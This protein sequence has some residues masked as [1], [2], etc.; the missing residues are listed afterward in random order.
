M[1][2]PVTLRQAQKFIEDHH[3]HNKPP[4][5]WKFGVGLVVDGHGMVGVAR[6]LWEIKAKE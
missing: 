2:V 5:G 6:V 3:R 4:R 1:I